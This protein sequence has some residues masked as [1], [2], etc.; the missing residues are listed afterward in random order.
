MRSNGPHLQVELL[1]VVT[2]E[3]IDHSSDG[4]GLASARVIEVKH[5]L[6]GTWLETIHERASRRV[7]GAVRRAALIRASFEPHNLIV[8]L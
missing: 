1:N 8:G 7:E 4:R 3:R 5:A 6:N 2:T